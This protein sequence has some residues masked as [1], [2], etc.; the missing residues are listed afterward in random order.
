V[1]EAILVDH[2]RTLQAA[3]DAAAK[4]ANDNSL[5]KGERA[6]AAANFDDLNSQL[7][8]MNQATR[9][10][11]IFKSKS[12]SLAWHQFRMKDYSLDSM[13]DKLQIAKNGVP[14]TKEEIS[15]LKAG[16][17]KLAGLMTRVGAAKAGALPGTVLP[18]LRGLQ[19]DMHRA[20]VALD[21]MVFH[22]KFRQ[23]PLVQRAWYSG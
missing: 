19:Y 16:T 21:D 7:E 2:R 1:D 15:K 20:K 12:Q 13:K 11:N 8:V 4:V 5:S 6:N 23:K 18:G 9:D 3:R 14:P 17:D 10:G 22:E